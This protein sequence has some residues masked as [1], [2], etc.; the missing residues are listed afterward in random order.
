[1]RALTGHPGND[2]CMGCGLWAST[3]AFDIVPLC[4]E[5]RANPSSPRARLA[6]LNNTRPPLPPFELSTTESI[7]LKTL[8]AGDGTGDRIIAAL[9]DL[10]PS[11]TY[12][13]V[14][15]AAS[16]GVWEDGVRKDRSV[17][18]CLAK[19]GISVPSHV[20]HALDRVFAAPPSTF[21]DTY[22][23]T[24][25]APSP[26]LLCAAAER[27]PSWFH[28]SMTAAT[29]CIEYQNF[30]GL[31]AAA[32]AWP[33][34][35]TAAT[36]AALALRRADTSW[37]SANPTSVETPESGQ[38]ALTLLINA[39]GSAQSIRH[40]LE[41]GAPASASALAAVFNQSSD[42]VDALSALDVL[43][44]YGAPASAAMCAAA[45]RGS[46][47][48]V[49]RLLDAN[50]NPNHAHH[51]VRPLTRCITMGQCDDGTILALLG[52]GAMAS[53]S[54]YATMIAIQSVK[55]TAVLDELLAAIPRAE[56]VPTTF[57]TTAD[58]IWV[59][60]E[61]G[62]V[63]VNRV[64]Y[65]I[66]HVADR[67]RLERVEAWRSTVARFARAWSDDAARAADLQALSCRY[68][69]SARETSPYQ[70]CMLWEQHATALRLYHER[71]AP[72]ASRDADALQQLFGGHDAP[73]WRAVY[74]ALVDSLEGILPPELIERIAR[75]VL[76]PP[77]CGALWRGGAAADPANGAGVAC[78][79]AIGD[80]AVGPELGVGDV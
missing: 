80:L 70:E 37:I 33:I 46:P 1:M 48:L 35:M 62:A 78:T 53:T 75:Q 2:D 41:L 16:I 52:A 56:W 3:Q 66:E 28:G 73:W 29:M 21:A 38:D 20:L 63:P 58:Q 12:P 69:N 61:L 24:A 23:L 64:H 34:P 72:V 71:L 59:S 26:T 76:C 14:L 19:L 40:L 30:A 65:M 79:A 74:A 6:V 45:E 68:G 55:S 31:F 39:G 77:P 60:H 54:L 25:L 17:W 10:G 32:R 47:M 22:T 43:L 7:V 5:C 11:D 44:E 50:G 49:A 13:G 67:F 8:L 42:D 9:R 18:W 36:A 4:P 51:G 27:W 15:A 57:A